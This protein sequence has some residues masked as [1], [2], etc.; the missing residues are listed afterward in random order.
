LY[1]IV[2]FLATLNFSP[3]ERGRTIRK[4]EDI[5]T[6]WK[7]G[8]RLRSVFKNST[9]HFIGGTKMKKVLASLV[10]VSFLA[11]FAFAGGTADEAKVLVEKAVSYIKSDGKDK[12]FSEFTNSK[13][14]FI[15]KD[16]YIFVVDFNGST[17]AHGGNTNL[18][19]KDMSELKDAD[20]EFFIKKMISVAKSKGSG[21][22]DYKWV[23]PVTKKIEPKSTYIQK[24]DTYFVGCGIYK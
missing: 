16:L 15:N 21:W 13:G 19:G 18:V 4:L 9:Q 11:S 10:I 12:A 14:K 3:Q 22:V 1:R 2:Y 23:N 7:R 17:L 5:L 20:G 8:R 6:V 24:N